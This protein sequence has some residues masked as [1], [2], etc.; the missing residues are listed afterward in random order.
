VQTPTF[1]CGSLDLVVSLVVKGGLLLKRWCAVWS[2]TPRF[3]A[4]RHHLDARYSA[5]H[6]IHLKTALEEA[7]TELSAHVTRSHPVGM[8]RM[9]LGQVPL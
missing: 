3:A 1:G 4:A 5:S 9:A 6:P 7:Q 8:Q 2:A